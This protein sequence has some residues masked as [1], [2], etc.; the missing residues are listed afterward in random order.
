MPRVTKACNSKR[1]NI[2]KYLMLQKDT[3]V[4]EVGYIK[5]LNN[6]ISN[7]CSMHLEIEKIKKKHLGLYGF[8][9]LIQDSRGLGVSYSKL[10]N[11][12]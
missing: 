3:M 2:K 8:Q 1:L 5:L 10:I 7:Q 4:L 11:S 6:L 9:E 12:L